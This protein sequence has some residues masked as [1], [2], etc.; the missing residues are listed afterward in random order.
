MLHTYT[1][2]AM[3]L[4]HMVFHCLGASPNSVWLAMRM[5]TVAKVFWC[6]VLSSQQG[7]TGETLT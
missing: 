4:A 5:S 1:Q 2:T 6:S 3:Q 7:N